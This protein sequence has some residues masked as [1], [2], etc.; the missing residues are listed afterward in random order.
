MEYSKNNKIFT[1]LKFYAFL[2]YKIVTEL[3][4]FIWNWL[5]IL[6]NNVL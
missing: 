6:R 1:M 2:Y 4:L 5:F 3:E